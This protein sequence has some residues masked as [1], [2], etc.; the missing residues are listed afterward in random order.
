MDINLG[1]GSLRGG[2]LNDNDEQEYRKKKSTIRAHNLILFL[3]GLFYPYN[4]EKGG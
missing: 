4:I 1:V 3:N 2:K